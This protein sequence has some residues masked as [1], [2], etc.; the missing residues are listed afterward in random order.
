MLGVWQAAEVRAAERQVLAGLPAG[1][2]MAKAARAVA[3]EATTMLGFTYG[4]KVM[5]LVGWGDNGADAL[6]AGAE[7]ARRGVRV[8]ALLADPDRTDVPALAAFRSAGG[9]LTEL[10][11]VGPAD[12]IVDGLVGIGAHG[13]LRE[14][15]VALVQHASISNAPV[16]AVDLPSGVDPDTGA[17]AGP[18][19]QATVTVCMGAF[20]AGLLIGEGRVRAGTIRLID[21]GLA[22]VLA[23]PASWQLTEDDLDGLLHRPGPFD[24]KYTRGVVGVA[25]GSRSYPGA[26]QLCVGAARLGGVGAVRY[27]GHAA[28]EVVRRWPE[29]LVTD[30]VSAAGRVQAWVVGPGL[31][32]TVEAIEAL[33]VVLD[34]DVPAVIDADGLNLLAGDDELRE[35]LERRTAVTVLT[36]HDREFERLFG[37]VGSDRIGSARRAAG[38]TGA[39]V[40]LKGFA[41]LVATPDGRSYLN[42][43]GHPA[44]ATAGSGDVLAGLTGSLLATGIE[45]GLAA[46]TAAYLHG[47]AAADASLA[48]PMVASDLIQALRTQLS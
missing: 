45:A 38:S 47:R 24:D 16:L 10:A 34:S 20:K 46:A 17:V 19:I 41:T 9:Q 12:L 29:V 18:A 37:A 21:L 6:F 23:E 27:A 39:T 42:P 35:L 11:S 40:L 31:G 1:A 3:V 15:M 22:T 2:L 5:L 13:P 28:A 14:P 43:T 25:A 48:G 44:L 33:R 7:L 32:D 36:P 30:T 4:A 26:A 8:S